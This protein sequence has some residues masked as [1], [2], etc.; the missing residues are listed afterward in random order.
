MASYVSGFLMGG[1]GNQLFIMAAV[2]GHARR[3]GA[4]PGIEPRC[5]AHSPHSREAY[6]DT[7]FAGFSRL[8]QATCLYT[9]PPEAAVR[10]LLDLPPPPDGDH[11]LLKG[12]FQH[13]GYLGEYKDEFIGMLRLPRVDP[14][15]GVCFL[16][17]RRND[18]LLPRNA[19]HN[20]DLRQYYKDAIAYVKG[21]RPDVRFLVFSDDIA[22]C[23]AQAVFEGMEFCDEAHEV[24]ALVKMSQC[25]VG[26]ITANSSF[27]W[28]GVILNRNP[29]KIVV[30]PKQWFVGKSV[31]T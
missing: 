3:H 19:I 11:L 30:M 7:V 13:E 12:Y 18:Y 15:E 29:D 2:Y 21:R 24:T 17:V 9:E 26:G 25:R 28:W 20:V 8:H 14:L 22:W 5:I 4:Q 31:N 23:R 16:H 10:T 6:E 27:S 1:L